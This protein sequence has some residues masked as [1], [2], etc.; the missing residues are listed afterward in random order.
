M[1]HQK[2]LLSLVLTLALVS[3]NT[4]Y[5]KS[6][7]EKLDI[8]WNQT[9]AS[10]HR[11][12]GAY[13]VSLGGMS[14]RSPIRNWTVVSY[15]P[16]NI[17]AGCGGI[18]AHF[19]S[20]SFISTDNI[21]QLMRN[22]I[23]NSTGYAIS[24][25]LAAVC[26]KCES[27]MSKMHEIT[28]QLNA[29]SSNTCRLS[30]A[31]VNWV[32]GKINPKANNESQSDEE[33]VDKNMS[34]ELHDIY[35]SFSNIFKG[36]TNAN[37]PINAHN[38]DTRYG[39]NLFNTYVS[40]KVFRENLVDTKLYGGDQQFF[41][42]AMSLIGTNIMR[43][44]SD[45]ASKQDKQD[46]YK[47]PIWTFENLFE[48]TKTGNS[49][50][51]MSC[52]D[53]DTDNAGSCQK[54]KNKK[55]EWPGTERIVIE[56]LAG[57]QTEVDSVKGDTHIYS[58]DPNSIV[59]YLKYGDEVKLSKKQLA[60]LSSIPPTYR[61]SLTYL[62]RSTENEAIVRAGMQSAVKDIAKQLAAHLAKEIIWT[63]RNAYNASPVSVSTSKAK[64]GAKMTDEQEKALARLEAKADEVLNNVKQESNA[65]TQNVNTLIELSH[66][67]Q[68][69]KAEDLLKKV[70]S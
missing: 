62:V 53:F 68:S 8:M 52:I 7:D 6:I 39:N 22:I 70:Q 54:V 1:K 64:Q 65:F 16:P 27:K 26:E 69:K 63:T 29:F 43:T 37:R 15:S 41:E 50:D 19:G 11:V 4:A 46:D 42:I 17:K 30:Q 40:A 55:N 57:K 25:A 48:G 9:Q 44:V 51:I 3:T 13:G 12:N 36:G 60:F 28:S 56:L 38:H 67:N 2:T 35:E 59:A 49:L 32:N 45:S 66:K 18:D 10:T 58:I 14:L 23:S 47:N 61:E 5:A 24:L 33:A 20:F 21:K 34:A 31:A